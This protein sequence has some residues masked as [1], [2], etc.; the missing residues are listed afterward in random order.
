MAGFN[1]GLRAN[2]LP[3]GVTSLNTGTAPQTNGGNTVNILEVEPGTLSMLFYAQAKVNLMTVEPQW[4]VS[5]D[6]STWYNAKA[7][8]N[9]AAVVAVT[10]TGSAVPG[11]VVVSAPD[12]VYGWAYARGAAVSR[13]ADA[14]D[15][16]DEYNISYN[17]LMR[18]YGGR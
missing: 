18:G 9:A 16:D 5:A 6:G 11:T 15:G 10:G 2:V 17:Y 13:V 3:L 12:C 7:P 1:T 8:N 14:V 4:Q